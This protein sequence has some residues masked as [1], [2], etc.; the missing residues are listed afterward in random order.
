MLFWEPFV[1]P[2]LRSNTW[3]VRGR[4][5]DLLVDT[6]LGVTSLRDA[7]SSFLERPVIAVATHTHY[8][9]V[10]SMLE[11]EQRV[12]HRAEASAL[13]SPDGHATLIRSDFNDLTVAMLRRAGY[14]LDTPELITA[15]P[16]AG[17]DPSSFATSP[18]IPTQVVDEGDV[19]DLGDRVFT[20]LHLP[21]HSP[22]SI[23]LWDPRT[24]TLFS[25]DALYDGPLLDELPG[26]SI[27]DYLRT[28]RRLRD[29]PVQVVHAGHDPS[30]DRRRL[31]ELTTAYIT[32]RETQ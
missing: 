15:Y 9:H 13:R 6:G 7:I 32:H 27:P 17:Y 25:G 3:L 1:D 20:V 18:A 4:N 30:F 2:L 31:V 8:D 29:L 28:M 24:G 23:G 19:I 22:G 16:V 11:F 12:V 26:S 5:A 10:G 21:G 14:P